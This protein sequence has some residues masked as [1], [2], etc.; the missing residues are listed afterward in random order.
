MPATDPNHVA[1]ARGDKLFKQGR[2]GPAAK[3]FHV[4]LEEWPQDWQALWALGNCFSEMK[5]PRKAEMCFRN[6]LELAPPN[7]R[8]KITFNLGNA[9]FDQRRFREAIGVYRQLPAGHDLVR[10]AKNNVVLAQERLANGT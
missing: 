8:P 9:L 3:W 1:Y 10:Q 5:K 6:A 2:F 7:D 4:A